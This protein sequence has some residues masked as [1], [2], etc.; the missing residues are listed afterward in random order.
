MKAELANPQSLIIRSSADKSAIGNWQSAF[1]K[2]SADK[3]AI[4]NIGVTYGKAIENWL[5]RFRQ[6]RSGRH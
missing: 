4:R 2:S 6:H 3:S 5:D 1:A